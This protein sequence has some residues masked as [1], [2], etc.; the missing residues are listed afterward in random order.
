MAQNAL[1]NPPS[2]PVT[3]GIRGKQQMAVSQFIK[4][5]GAIDGD[6]ASSSQPSASLKKIDLHPHPFL[7]LP[8][9]ISPNGPSNFFSLMKIILPTPHLIGQGPLQTAGSE[10]HLRALILWQSASDLASNRILPMDPHQ[11]TKLI[12]CEREGVK[13]AH[14]FSFII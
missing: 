13:S 14:N 5:E 4:Q 6:S 8:Q 1:E 10:L 11:P 9:S 2:A 7:L 12:P 3:G